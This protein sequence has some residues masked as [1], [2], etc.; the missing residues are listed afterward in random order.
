M[1]ITVA[2][3]CTRKRVTHVTH[4]RVTPPHVL[5][6]K[7]A[8]LQDIGPGGWGRAAVYAAVCAPLWLANASALALKYATR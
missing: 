6:T 8:Q 5:Q 1:A 3:G 2:H 4:R 7:A